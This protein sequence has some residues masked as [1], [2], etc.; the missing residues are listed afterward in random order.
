MPDS[1]Q[2]IDARRPE[3]TLKS[4]FE[5][6]LAAGRKE[7]APEVEARFYP[8]AGLSSTIRLRRG[9]VYVRVSDVLAGSPPEVLYALA[10]MLVAKLYKRKVSLEDERIYRQYTS[11]REVLDASESARRNRGYKMITTPRGNVYDLDQTFDDLNSRYFQGLLERPRLSWSP[12]RPRRILGHHD[13]VH[14]TIIIS[15]ALDNAGI[16]KFVL[17]YVLYHEM[18]HVKHAPTVRGGRTV[19]HSRQFRADERRFERFDEA[20]RLLE[21]IAPRIRR[22]RRLGSRPVHRNGTK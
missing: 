22:R 17:E 15:R 14:R 11:Q 2:L 12:G 4:V 13:H 21:Q 10:C 3:A 18:L 19:Y 6:A 20:L 8:Y 5:A 9:R 1:L 7:A 16:P